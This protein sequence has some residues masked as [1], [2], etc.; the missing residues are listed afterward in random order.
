MFQ[1]VRLPV[2]VD[3][4]ES[5]RAIRSGFYP[6]W[7]CQDW[8]CPSH[9]ICGRHF[10][11]SQRYAAMGE[12]KADDA[13]CSPRRTGVKCEHFTAATYDH[14]AKAFIGQAGRA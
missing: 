7:K 14:F 10:G 1:I 11:L 8:R 13:L 4:E 9:D 6:N 3:H 12:M 2:Y 5:E